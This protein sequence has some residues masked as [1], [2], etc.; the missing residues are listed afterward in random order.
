MLK[1]R[2]P[3]RDVVEDIHAGLS[4]SAIKD[5]YDLSEALL[6]RLFEKLYSARMISDLD[7]Q[8]RMEAM[9]RGAQTLDQQYSG[10]ELIEFQDTPVRYVRERIRGFFRRP[11]SGFRYFIMGLCA[12]MIIMMVILG[13]LY[14]IGP[15]NSQIGFIIPGGTSVNQADENGVTFLMKAALQ[16]NVERVKTLIRQG[17]NVNAVD[18]DSET[19]LMAAAFNGNEQIVQILLEK[20]AIVGIRNNRGASAIDIARLRGHLDVAR[21]LAAHMGKQN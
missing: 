19:A 20:G 12:S 10:L 18:K 16:G 9:N 8:E 21:K 5:K 7:Y 13:I 6:A 14:R 3:A 4:N 17:A 1:R 15:I 2:I 11:V